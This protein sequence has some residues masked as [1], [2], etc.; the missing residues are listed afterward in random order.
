MLDGL[1]IL[2]CELFPDMCGAV[3]VI[4]II[5]REEVGEEEK[6][7]HYKEYEKLQENDHPKSLAYGHLPKT[8]AIEL[9]YF[10]YSVHTFIPIGLK[11]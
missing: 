5:A 10:Y 3:G 7:D 4:I 1:K 11:P 9:P 6:L 2:S 8:V